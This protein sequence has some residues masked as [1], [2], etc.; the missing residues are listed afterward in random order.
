[1]KAPVAIDLEKLE[2]LD[3]SR[4]RDKSRAAVRI[5]DLG[6]I[7][8]IPRNLQA[9]EVTAAP[10]VAQYNQLVN[11][12]LMLHRQLM[13]VQRKLGDRIQPRVP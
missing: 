10:T 13:V 8:E 4:N 9:T 6:G 1:M 7:M 12:V 2:V 5:E 11:D 3:G